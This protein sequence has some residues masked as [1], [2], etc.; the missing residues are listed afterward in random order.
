M[1]Q[2][3]MKDET[4]MHISRFMTLPPLPLRFGFIQ[5]VAYKDEILICSAYE[6]KCYSYHRI[7]NEYKFICLYP[8]SI[9]LCGHCVIK[10]VD[11]KDSNEITLLSFGGTHTQVLMMKYISVW[12]S[13]NKNNVSSMRYNQWHP[14]TNLRRPIDIG[15]DRGEYIGARGVIAG[16]KNHLLFITSYPKTISVFDTCR[17]QFIKHDILPIDDTIR[18]HCFVSKPTLKN[19]EMLLFYKN[20][21]LLIQ[22]DEYNKTFEFH[23]IR[24]CKTMRRDS[25]YAFINIGNSIL[26]FG[27]DISDQVYR[28][29]ITNNKWMMHEQSLIKL[30]N[31][32]AVLSEDSNFVHIF[33][34]SY[35]DRNVTEHIKIRV[36]E[37]MGEEEGKW[38]KEE[39]GKWMIEEEE[40]L[41][42]GNEELEL[43]KRN[44]E[45]EETENKLDI[46][47]IKVSNIIFLCLLKSNIFFYEIDIITKYWMH[48]LLINEMGWIDHFSIMVLRYILVSINFILKFSADGTK[49]FSCS[50][51]SVI[52]IWDVTSGNITQELQADTDNIHFSPDGNMIA[53]CPTGLDNNRVILHDLKSGIKRTI[54]DLHISDISLIQFSPDGNTILSCSRNAINIWNI[55]SGQEVFR[56]RLPH[57]HNAKFSPN[58]QQLVV[59]VDDKITIWNV[60]S[61]KMIY[62]STKFEKSIETVQFFADG[63][64]ILFSLDNVVRILDVTSGKVIKEFDEFPANIFEMRYFLD[65][66]TILTSLNGSLRLLDVKSG[67]EIQR[68]KGQL[69][70]VT[71]L[72]LAPDGNTIVA[73]SRGGAIQLWVPL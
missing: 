55:Q 26:F 20:S 3:D 14:F 5:C 68:L 12:N 45:L 59:A 70:N 66:Q 23:R 27:C 73:G 47:Q 56:I 67:V 8:Y 30:K 36:N 39:E 72:D 57:I 69:D 35:E 1:S 38:V 29:S 34:I 41:I 65:G 25:N 4:T 50:A 22:Y 54:T 10:L 13:D 31:C 17:L 37:L 11:N 7:K 19:N 62:K 9:D 44:I 33:G 63:H 32:T 2:T 71:V 42:L 18:F 51:D 21:G 61:G 40:K 15:N 6:K 46:K 28:F 53:Y 64:S 16:T 48:S 58:G 49:I 52:K 24:V 60:S 43:E